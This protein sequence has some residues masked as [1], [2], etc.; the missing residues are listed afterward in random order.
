MIGWRPLLR[1]LPFQ[2]NP[3]SNIDDSLNFFTCEKTLTHQKEINTILYLKAVTFDVLKYL[4]KDP[5]RYDRR[6][7]ILFLDNWHLRTC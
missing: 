3:L 5:L 1:F 4:S 7:V 2:V 6:V